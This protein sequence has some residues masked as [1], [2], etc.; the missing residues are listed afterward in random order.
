MYDPM[1]TVFALLAVFS[2]SAAHAAVYYVSPQGKADAPGTEA[3]PFAF[4]QDALDRAGA[5]D[6]VRL[7]PGVYRE[8]VSFRNSGEFGRPVVLEGSGEAVIDAGLPQA[9]DWRPAPDIGPGVYRA[10]PSEYVITLTADGKTIVMLDERQVSPEAIRRLLDAHEAG[11]AK[12]RELNWMGIP[13][14]RLSWPEIFQSGMGPYG[15]KGLR[16]VAMYRDKERDLLLRFGDGSDPRKME[17]RVAKKGAAITIFGVSRCVVRNLTI[18]NAWNAVAIEESLGSVV[19]HCRIRSGDHGVTLGRGAEACTIR[20]NEFSMDMY[21]DPDPRGEGAWGVWVAIKA[22]GFND[23]IAVNILKSAGFHR[24]YDNLVSGHWGGVQDIGGPGQN[25]GLDVHHNRLDLIQDDGLEPNGAEENSRWHHNI[26]TRSRCAI[27]LKCISKGPFYAYNNI[28]YDNL[29][30]FRNFGEPRLKKGLLYIYQNTSTA[31][32]AI[33][34]NKIPVGIGTPNY[35]FFNNLFHCR[36]WFEGGFAKPDWKG[37]FNV[38]I[39][40]GEGGR[41]WEEGMALA[42][43]QGIDR[44]SL[45]LAASPSG[46]SNPEAGDFS[47]TADSPAR[48][49]GCDLQ[50]TLGVELPG[51]NGITPDCGALPYGEPMPRLPRPDDGK[52]PAGSWP[53]PEAEKVR[54]ERLRQA[55]EAAVYR[56]AGR[57]V[58]IDLAPFCNMGFQDEV[59][60]DGKGGAFDMGADD[61]R[62]FPTGL[63]RLAGVPFRI[64]ERGFSMIVLQSPQGRSFPREAAGIP[65]GRKVKHLYFLHT[66]AWAWTGSFRY[67]IHYADGESR[68]LDIRAGHEVADWCGPDPASVPEAKVGWTGSNPRN[69]DIGVYVWRWSNPRPEAEIRAFDIVSLPEESALQP[70][71]IAVTAELLESAESLPPLAAGDWRVTDPAVSHLSEQS[72]AGFTLTLDRAGKLDGAALYRMTRFPRGGDLEFSCRYEGAEPGMGYLQVKAPAGGR[73]IRFTTEGRERSGTLRVVF[74]PGEAE[75]LEL[76]C[77]I[78]GKTQFE[79]GSVRFSD[80]RFGPIENTVSAK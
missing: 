66:A 49:R 44:R 72:P 5:G 6:T 63:R 35:H 20:F 12:G 39:R 58:F 54:Q 25:V 62:N 33:Y 78:H 46:F 16:A 53:G 75:Q 23:R 19:E 17:T 43:R 15:W 67:R 7:L 52:D 21:S 56:P 79:G 50:K 10:F 26:V 71:V 22:C 27:R 59:A 65:V 28:L 57:C 8:C 68:S 37:D 29:E 47:L 45:W 34:N 74:D 11:P 38:Y 77:R 64:L 60:G 80:F 48:K 73:D 76:L 3:A 30:D 31:D 24:V 13:V 36:G 18:R 1:K 51:A 70:G 69:P 32:R 55:A 40:R 4:I 41:E 2:L 14:R 42:A 61:L 9:L